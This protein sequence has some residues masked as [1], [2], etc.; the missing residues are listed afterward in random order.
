MGTIPPLGF[1][2]WITSVWEKSNI[3]VSHNPVRIHCKAGSVSARLVFET[4]AKCQDFVGLY[5]DG[6]IPVKLTVCSKEKTTISVRQSK[7]LEDREIGEAICAF[8]ESVGRTAQNSFLDGDD[9]GAFI[10][11]ALDA[12][13]QVLSIKNRS[14]GVGKKNVQTCPVL[15][16]ES[17]SLL[18]HLT[19]VFPG[20][21]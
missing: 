1:A 8:V 21:S 6:G 18:L 2:N 20:V 17:C 5:K 19:C 11:P 4:R 3:P 10:V 13:S 14:N 16:V 12:R 7:S 9:R 15:E